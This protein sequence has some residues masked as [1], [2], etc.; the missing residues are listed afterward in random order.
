M[1]ELVI[2]LPAAAVDEP[3]FIEESV[4]SNSLVKVEPLGCYLVVENLVSKMS[5]LPKEFKR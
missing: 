3:W 4:S 5:Q 2:N 1:L